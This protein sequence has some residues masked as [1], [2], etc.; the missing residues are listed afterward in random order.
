MEESRAREND[1][2][3]EQVDE[4]TQQLADTKEKLKGA[5]ARKKVLENQLKDIKG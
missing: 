3:K 5:Q 2:L 1:N 4:L